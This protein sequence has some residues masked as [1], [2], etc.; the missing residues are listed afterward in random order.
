MGNIRLSIGQINITNYLKINFRAVDDPTVLLPQSETVPPPVPATQDKFYTGFRNVPHYID[1]RSSDD[2]VAQGLLLATFVYDV[3]NE[4]I[5]LE[6]RFYTVGGL[7][8]YDPAP[9]TRTITDP[10]FE[11]K[12]IQGVFKEGFRYL[13]PDVEY[14]FAT[15]T[16]T[17]DSTLQPEFSDGEKISVEINWLLNTSDPGMGAG[18]WPEDIIDI[19]SNATLDNSHYNKELVVIGAA[20]VVTLTFPSFDDIPDGTKFGFNT[21]QFDNLRYLELILPATK[22]VYV[23]GMQRNELYMGRGETLWMQKK[24]DRMVI[25]SWDGDYL[26]VGEIVHGDKVPVNGIREQGG[27]FLIDEYPRFYYWFVDEIDAGLLGSGTQAEGIPALDFTKFIKDESNGY[28][29]IPDSRGQ[30][31]RHTDETGTIDPGRVS[32]D[33]KPGTRQLDKV[34]EFQLKL[35]KANGF[36]GNPAPADVQKF[37]YGSANQQIQTI[38]VNSGEGDTKPKNVTRNIYR[39]L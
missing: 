11:G 27:W 13:E 38:T 24:A 35:I 9:G 28:F 34:G 37:A 26:R 10:Y 14:V 15:D 5:I 6:R 16:V 19:F 36:T 12:T 2:G 18:S 17:M 8:E 33:R 31:L 3:R 23:A 7:G 4:Q 20:T 39:I 1:F 29:W 25:L 32:A 21:H 22:Y 30:F